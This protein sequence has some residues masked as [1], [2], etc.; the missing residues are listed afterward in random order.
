MNKNTAQGKILIPFSRSSC[1]LPYC[2]SR[3]AIEFWWTNQEFLSADIITPP[4][5]SMFIYR[6]GA[7]GTLVAA[8]Q[9]RSLTP[10]M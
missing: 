9:R 5:F 4:W 7:I 10:S 2:A 8:V 6:L 1:L 3:T